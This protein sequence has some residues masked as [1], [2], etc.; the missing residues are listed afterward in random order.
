MAIADPVRQA[1]LPPKSRARKS[2]VAR[3]DRTWALPVI[4]G[5][6]AFVLIMVALGDRGETVAVAVARE[7][8]AAGSRVDPSSLRIAKVPKG[9]IAD[10]LLSFDTATDDEFVALVPIRAGDPIRQ[11]DV[12]GAMAYMGLR[13]MAIPVAPENAAGGELVPGD[14][15]DVV[16]VVDGRSAWVAT[17][18]EVI[19]VSRRG[20]G[21]GADLSRKDFLLVR[22]DADQA[23]A[24]AAAMADGK[25]DVVR[26]T[27]APEV[28]PS[29]PTAE[30]QGG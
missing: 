10:R 26:A 25:L 9:E 6:L 11:A 18:L 27:G 4:T 5:L 30:G 3:I 21:F 8:V 29:R 28:R 16:D 22:V 13:T 14:R 24:L 7:D 20:A 15:V 2:L 23:L 17:G 12:V 1:D 19:A